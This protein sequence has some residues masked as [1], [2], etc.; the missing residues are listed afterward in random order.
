MGERERV[1]LPCDA[2]GA[3]KHWPGRASEHPAGRVNL[4]ADPVI[5]V[6]PSLSKP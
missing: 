6:K 2:G 5:C 4:P 1:E 3:P